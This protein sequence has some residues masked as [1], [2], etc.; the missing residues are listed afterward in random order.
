MERIARKV[1]IEIQT[2]LGYF[3]NHDNRTVETYSTIGEPEPDYQCSTPIMKPKYFCKACNSE[4][5][6]RKFGGRHFFCST[7]CKKQY[8]HENRNKQKV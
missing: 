5:E 1:L 2:N 3:E 6:L 7:K 8:Y 4:F